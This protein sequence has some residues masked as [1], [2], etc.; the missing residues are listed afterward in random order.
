[1]LSASAQASAEF[2][3]AEMLAALLGVEALLLA[4]VGISVSLA[5]SSKLGNKWIVK[6]AAFA[7]GNTAILTLITL[8]AGMVWAKLFAG[9]AWPDSCELRAGALALALAVVAPPV[10]SLVLSIN[11]ASK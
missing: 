3:P 9:A 11:L 7:F 10:I 8:G 5:V 1:V 2:G 4:A 6:P